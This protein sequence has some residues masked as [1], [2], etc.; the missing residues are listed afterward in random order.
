M[1][2]RGEYANRRAIKKRKKFNLLISNQKCQ[3]FLTNENILLIHTTI[4]M[5]LLSLFAEKRNCSFE[6]KTKFGNSLFI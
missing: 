2:I 6:G 3:M 5:E 1:I 4:L